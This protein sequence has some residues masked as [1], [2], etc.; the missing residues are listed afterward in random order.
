M[1]NK[2]KR[3]NGTKA[4][5][6]SVVGPAER[7]EYVVVPASSGSDWHGQYGRRPQPKLKSE[8]PTYWYDLGRRMEAAGR[9]RHAESMRAY[10][11]ALEL[12][13]EHRDARARLDHLRRSDRI[14][15]PRGSEDGH[16]PSR[17]HTKSGERL[18]EALLTIQW[19]DINQ[20][21]RS[22]ACPRNPK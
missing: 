16:E 5:N 13:P 18:L 11:K 2:A 15:E 12:K 1:K 8:D 17:L 10:A 9:D 14:V 7:L 21:A 22:L 6:G 19:S 3:V 20:P 4:V